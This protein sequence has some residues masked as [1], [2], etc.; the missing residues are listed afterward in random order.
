MLALCDGGMGS[1]STQ[2]YVED[3]VNEQLDRAGTVEP[4]AKQCACNGQS[5]QSAEQ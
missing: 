3:E 4:R 2:Q 5:H 1:A